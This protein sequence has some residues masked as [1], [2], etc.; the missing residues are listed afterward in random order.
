MN[1]VVCEVVSKDVVFL[2]SSWW[3]LLLSF[4]VFLKLICAAKWY[5]VLWQSSYLPV[6][7]PINSVISRCHVPLCKRVRKTLR[8]HEAWA[9]LLSE[10]TRLA[11]I[12]GRQK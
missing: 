4:F 10:L 6:V 3:E 12:A 8:I 7:S 11:G 2:T 9:G 5:F 1:C